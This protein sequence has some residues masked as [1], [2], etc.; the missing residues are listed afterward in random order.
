MQFRRVTPDDYAPIIEV[1]DAW[2]GGRKMTAMLP[3]L[4][5]VHFRDTSFIAELD[6]N[7]IGFLV[8]FLSPAI[9]EEAYIHFVGVHPDHRNRGVGR[10]LYEQFVQMARMAGRCQVSCVTAPVNNPSIAFHRAL[11][12]LPC[13]SADESAEVPFYPNHDGPGE[14]R[15]LLVKQL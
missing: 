6:G 8:G 10:G 11:G 4:F 13:G 3:K 15:V 2:W 7:L 5:F 14:D 9:P 1:L 12:F